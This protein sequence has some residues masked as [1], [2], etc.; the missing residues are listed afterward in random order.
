[1]DEDEKYQAFLEFYEASIG[2]LKYEVDAGLKSN[3]KNL[4]ITWSM[5]D[6]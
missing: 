1:M 5:N 2:G 6:E 4:T 3:T